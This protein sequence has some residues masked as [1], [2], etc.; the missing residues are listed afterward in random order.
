MRQLQPVAWSKGV[1]LSPQHLQAQDHFAEDSLRF[2][3]E[4]NGFRCWGFLSVSVDNA[5]LSEGRFGISQAV[6]L[7]PDSLPFDFPDADTSPQSRSL[8]DCFSPTQTSRILYLSVPE[9]RRG[10]INIAQRRSGRNT[11]FFSDLQLLR[12]ENS[13]GVEKPVSVARKNLQ[14]LAEGESL[15]GMVV[16]PVARVVRTEAGQ[17][18]LDED[19]VPSMINVQGNQRLHGILRGIVEVLGSRSN[20]L[21]GGRRAR[22]QSL[23]E[24]SA[25]DIANFWLL[26]TANTHLPALIQLL[27]TPQLHP[28]PLFLQLLALAGAL[29]TFSRDINPQDL[30]RYDHE[31]LGTCFLQLESI[32]LRLLDT[33]IP[34]RF[35][36][37]P[38]TLQRDSIYATDLNFDDAFIE[39][40]RFYLAIAAELPTADLVA[41]TPV[42][43]KAGSASHIDTLVRQA[44]PGLPGTHLPAPPHEIPV[45]LDY[46]YFSLDHAGVAW[47]SIRRARNFAVY[48]PSEIHNPRL[49]LILLHPPEIKK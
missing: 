14:I 46:Q 36:A 29:T 4:A 35:T 13:T 34:S 11:R 30:P 15:E 47:E 33:V 20:Q 42:L 41:R 25:S 8:V 31:H 40:S 7:F 9:V 26:Y 10:G 3:A 5:A 2:L 16:L 44:L 27:H 24:F 6:G 49:E 39:G 12:D 17:F 37:L 48:V 45:K 1:F 22:S 18:R 28:E 43:V 21:S 19:F 23:A 38:L 32:V